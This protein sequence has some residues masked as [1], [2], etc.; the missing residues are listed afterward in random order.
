[1]FVALCHALLV[2]LAGERQE[3]RLKQSEQCLNDQ[4]REHEHTAD[5]SESLF[6]LLVSFS[7]SGFFDNALVQMTQQRVE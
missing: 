7:E 2:Q 3:Q 4:V 1:L 5:E 6:H